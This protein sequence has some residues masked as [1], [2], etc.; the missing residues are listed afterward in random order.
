[1]VAAGRAGFQRRDKDKVEATYSPDP[2]EEAALDRAA[3]AVARFNPRLAD[4]RSV[5]AVAISGWII[6]RTATAAARRSQFLVFDLGDAR[7][8]GFIEAALPSIG[9]AVAH[10]PGD[11]AFFE[12]DKADIVDLFAAGIRGAQEAAVLCNESLGFPFDDDIPFGDHPKAV[13]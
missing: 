13:A 1:M 10:L 2:E 9:A 7:L 11:V 4:P 8:R 3:D 6:A 12:L 5:A